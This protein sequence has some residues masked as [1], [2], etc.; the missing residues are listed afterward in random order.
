MPLIPL[1]PSW[2]P[3]LDLLPIAKETAHKF[4][5]AVNMVAENSITYHH[6]L[7]ETAVPEKKVKISLG[8]PPWPCAAPLP[9]GYDE[10]LKMFSSAPHPLQQEVTQKIGRR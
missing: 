6:V 8:Y 5:L 9:L 1:R 3:H 2:T 4:V 10:A 7:F